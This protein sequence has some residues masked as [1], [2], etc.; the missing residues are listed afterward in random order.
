[1][2]VYLRPPNRGSGIIR[3]IF[4]ILAL[5]EGLE[6]YGKKYLNSRVCVQRVASGTRLHAVRLL[7]RPYSLI[8]FLVRH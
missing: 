1:M 2:A 8:V 4:Q 6:I 7:T 5:G 3:A